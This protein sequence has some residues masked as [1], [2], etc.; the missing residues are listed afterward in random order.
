MLPKLVAFDVDGTL[1]DYEGRCTDR[2]R[3]ALIELRAHGVAT[4]IATGRPLASVPETLGQVGQVDFAVC[5]NGGVVVELATQR[6]IRRSSVPG[7]LV[8]IV[9]PEMRKRLD[10]VGVAI[11]IGD[12]TIEEPGFD[13]RLPPRTTVEPVDD[14]YAALGSPAPDVGR[15]IFFHDDFDA[16]IPELADIVRPLLDDRVEIFHGVLL[17]IVEVIPAGDNKAV[18]LDALSRD[19]GIA[20]DGVM[21]FGDGTNDLEMLEWAG[22]GVAMA[23]SADVTLAVADV[24]AASV[25][26]DGVAVFIESLLARHKDDT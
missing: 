10:G 8:D 25:D 6:V 18:A 17:P 23:N 12:R 5:G 3:R 11:D 22:T 19:L 9:V 16:A 7:G 15:L 24:V 14:A 13:R 26:D 20:V 21:A 4:A 1:I 2:T